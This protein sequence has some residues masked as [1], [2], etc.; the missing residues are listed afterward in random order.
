MI[1]II[2]RAPTVQKRLEKA[3]FEKFKETRYP[4]K[5][6][7][8]ASLIIDELRDILKASLFQSPEFTSLMSG[9]LRK[10]FGLSDE[11]VAELAPII[12]NLATVQYDVEIETNRLIINFYIEAL[13]ESEPL[14]LSALNRASYIS[15]KSGELIDWLRW[16]IYEGTTKISQ[17]HRVKTLEGKGRSHMGVMIIDKGNNGF[18]VDPQF[19]GV[20]GAN[21]VSRSIL[22]AWP[23]IKE[24]LA[25]HV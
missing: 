23:S 7:K 13:D 9:T 8:S 17:T 3:I 18:S 2:N 11:K 21:F 16:L 15:P 10:D 4:I 5:L 6:D 19:A 20:A 1:R 12:M 25:Q 22:A 24:R 14:T